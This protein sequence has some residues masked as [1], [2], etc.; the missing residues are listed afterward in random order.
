M[1]LQTFF[2]ICLQTNAHVLKTYLCFFL[3]FLPYLKKLFYLIINTKY[4]SMLFIILQPYSNARMVHTM[5]AIN[6][7]ETFILNANKR[8]SDV[9]HKWGLYLCLTLL[10]PKLNNTKYLYCLVSR[11][12]D[13]CL[14][15]WG[16][17]KLAFD[18]VVIQCKMLY[19][20]NKWEKLKRTSNKKQNKMHE[21]K[22]TR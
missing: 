22:G 15:K 10:L 6:I 7:N 4:K 2:F 19:N 17:L 3:H 13:Y 20:T 11:K 12:I 5:V 14:T 8:P 18:F 9:N 1:H 21:F 16:D